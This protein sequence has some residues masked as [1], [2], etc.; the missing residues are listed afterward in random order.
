MKKHDYST[1]LI[2]SAALVTVIRY[3]GAFVASDAGKI[4]GAY[5]DW[6]TFF[7]GLSGLGMGILDVIGGVYLFDGWRHAM[8][9]G[10]NAWSMRFQVLTFFVMGLILVGIG[11]LI[12]FTV[13]RV[14]HSDMETVLTSLGEWA[15]WAWSLLVNIAPYFLIGGVTVGNSLISTGQAGASAGGTAGATSGETS[16][17][18][19]TGRR[20]TT[21]TRTEKYFIINTPTKQCQAEFG[22]TDTAIKEWRKSIK[23]EVEQGRL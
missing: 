18:K 23:T 15:P 10:D 21:L 2:W 12:P 20:Y 9:K 6:L 4:T 1:L 5:S 14:A 3:A 22:V 7:M 11:I 16:P 17:K 8:P 13:S 19:A